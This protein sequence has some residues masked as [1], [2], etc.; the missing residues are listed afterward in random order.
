MR[1]VRYADFI[2]HPEQPME[3]IAEFQPHGKPQMAPVNVEAMRSF[4]AALDSMNHQRFAAGLRG[5]ARA[6]SLQSD[7]NARVFRGEI[8]GERASCLVFMLRPDEARDW[9]IRG[10]ALWPENVY[11]QFALGCLA[12]QRGEFEL[13]IT[14]LDSVLR[15]SST[16]SAAR[17][18]RKRALE[19]MAER[20][21]GR[22]P[23]RP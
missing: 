10:T 19:A 22:S 2:S 21:R 6:E 1:W 17:E 7:S 12:Y 9:A 13:A 11:A 8:W 3:V 5:L 4:L 18:V 14:K 15:F 16:Y 23:V 20:D